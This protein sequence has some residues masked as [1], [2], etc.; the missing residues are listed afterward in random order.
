MPTI[1]LTP[2]ILKETFGD[3]HPLSFLN[4]MFFSVPLMIINLILS[5]FWLTSYE[6]LARKLGSLLKKSNKVG[7]GRMQEELDN[8]SNAVEL[9]QSE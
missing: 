7:H 2:Q 9:A 6:K 8:A 3:S 5:F 1:R 4:W